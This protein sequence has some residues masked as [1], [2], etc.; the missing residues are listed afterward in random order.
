M[1]ILQPKVGDRVKVRQ[2]TWVVQDVDSYDGCRI[3]TLSGNGDGSAL[4]TCRVIHPFDD[5]AAVDLSKRPTRVGPRAWRRACRSLI[6]SDGDASAL[7]TAGSAR[8]DLLPYQL[9]PALA[10]L[11]GLG[12]RLLIADEVGLGKT[13]QEIGRAHV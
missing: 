1:D 5:V 2:R 12:V 13:V 6:G 7:R 11:R 3:L 9:E 10:L 4:R 8:I